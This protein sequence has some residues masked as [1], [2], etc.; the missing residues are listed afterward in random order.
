MSGDLQFKVVL[1]ADAQGFTVALRDAEGQLQR[2]ADQAR[3]AGEAVTRAGGAVGEAGGE[4]GRMGPAAETAGRAIADIGRAGAA[5]GEAVEALSLR[6]VTGLNQAAQAGTIARTAFDAAAG[7]AVQAGDATVGAA[8]GLNTLAGGVNSA[9]AQMAAKAEIAAG[10]IGRLGPAAMAAARAISETGQAALGASRG[11]SE[12]GQAAGAAGD[13]VETLSLRALRAVTGLN[14]AAQVGASAKTAFAAAAGAAIKA[15]DATAGAGAGLHTLAAGVNSALT[16][17]AAKTEISAGQMAQAKMIVR[18]NLMD[19]GNVLIATGGH[20]TSVLAVLPDLFYGLEQQGGRLA[21]VW[22][23]LAGPLGM[24]LLAAGAF[25]PALIEMASATD[26]ATTAA[27]EHK[28]ALEHADAAQQRAQASVSELAKRYRDLGDAMRQVEKIDMARALRTYQEDWRKLRDDFLLG[29]K[30]ENGKLVEGFETRLAEMS[31]RGMFGGVADDLRTMQEAL[32]ASNSGNPLA[33]LVVQLQAVREQSEGV[34]HPKAAAELDRMIEQAAAAAMKMQAVD[35]SIAD[36]SQAYAIAGED[37]SHLAGGL[38]EGGSELARFIARAAG[39]ADVAPGMAALARAMREVEAAKLLAEA[40]DYRLSGALSPDQYDAVTAAIGRYVEQGDAAFAPPK[41][42]KVDEFTKALERLVEAHDPLTA[43]QQVFNEELATVDKGYAQG[44]ISAEQYQTILHSM[45]DAYADV[46]EAADKA[47]A[48]QRSVRDDLA[49]QLE[50]IELRLRYEGDTSGELEVQL[51]MLRIRRQLEAA[52]VADAAA[53]AATYEDQVRAIVE[54]NRDLER[55][56]RELATPMGQAFQRVAGEVE[57]GFKDAFKS[58]FK[59][60]E[61]GWARLMDGFSNLFLDMLA[62]LAWQALARPIVVPVMQEVGGMMGLSP[63]ATNKALGVEGDAV[64]GLSSLGRAFTGSG[65]GT[66]TPGLDAW[67]QSTFGW[68]QIGLQSVGAAGVGS[69]GGGAAASLGVAAVPGGVTNAAAVAPGL[70]NGGSAFGGF[71]SLGNVLGI[72]GAVLPGLMSGNYGQAAA[73]GI[74]AAIGTIILP[75]IG[76]MIGGMLGNLVGGMFGGPTPH[77]AYDVRFGATDGRLGYV[78]G[79]QKHYDDALLDEV[80]GPIELAL[81]TA[82][83]R[84][85]PGGRAVGGGIYALGWDEEDKQYRV[86][87]AT[88][89]EILSEHGE[90]Q[91]GAVGAL[92]VQTI[93]N[94]EWEGV[95]AEVAEAVRR[96]TAENLDALAVDIQFA[97]DFDQTITRL[98]GGIHATTAAAEDAAEALATGLLTQVQQFKAKTEELGLDMG[99]ANRGMQALVL[100]AMGL[101]EVQQPLSA[102]DQAIVSATANMQ[103]MLP[104][105]LEVGTTTAEALDLIDRAIGNARAGIAAQGEIASIAATRDALGQGYVNDLFDVIAGRMQQTVGNADIYNGEFNARVSRL[106][107]GLDTDQLAVVADAMRAIADPAIGAWAQAIAD[108]AETISA[109]TAAADRLLTA[110]DAVVQARERMLDGYAAEAAALEEAESRWRSAAE[111]LRNAWVANQIGARSPLSP[112]DQLAA[113]RALWQDALNRSRSSDEEVATE[114]MGELAELSQQYLD[115]ALQNFGA[116]ERYYAIWA[117]VQS[118]LAQAEA[119]AVDQ[120]DILRDQRDLLRDQVAATGALTTVTE[121]GFRDLVAAYREAMAAAAAAQAAARAPAVT[122]GGAGAPAVTPAPAP[123]TQ[124][125]R[126]R[127][128]FDRY[129]DVAAHYGGDLSRAYTHYIVYGQYEGR[130]FEAGGTTRDGEVVRVHNHELLYTGP[131]ARVFNARETAEILGGGGGSDDTAA[132]RQVAG[133]R[134]QV[135]ALTREVA[136]LRADA[137]RQH[138]EAQG[139]RQRTAHDLALTTAA[140]P[141]AGGRR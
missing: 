69:V 82:V 119:V 12:A 8:A 114:A 37:F 88:T 87:D 123:L 124:E 141:P 3:Q 102:M 33:E 50:E 86:H 104:A 34:I 118:Q 106:L 96:S 46:V 49:G 52:G 74:G 139:L 97:R 73:G 75:G 115:V 101:A 122:A 23:V 105:L 68:G 127:A 10:E 25:A 117:E 120:A 7:A 11:I 42:A 137:Q 51:E 132:A 121:A 20:I 79:A 14:Q 58:A 19:V 36:V 28:R 83:D 43:A 84:L 71:A 128:Y 1:T 18:R 98:T 24:V 107:Q 6:A 35:D 81:Q 45:V 48:T 9:M 93:K 16:E 40:G 56:A 41:K 100:T 53:V 65:G 15:G 80:A 111:A 26:D 70:M 131:S 110:E 130:S 62:E 5:A 29:W 38:A 95:G 140:M 112:G 138:A 125:D 67:A 2:T 4:I 31:S 76:T 27:D 61:D 116:S 94:A 22:S 55:V 99:E 103:A 133:L 66:L 90:D 92:I 17:M 134:T 113:A 60:G 91:A 21:R 135:E 44:R 54:G 39:A 63:A 108:M 59:E 78:G 126:A 89:A 47:G 57:D 136:A 129:P 85:L 109:E 30:D 64:G 72:A 13:E 32:A 77:P